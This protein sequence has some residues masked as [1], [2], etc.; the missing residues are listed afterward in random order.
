MYLV[1]EI[2]DQNRNPN[3]KDTNT[4]ENT[5]TNANK[6]RNTKVSALPAPPSHLELERGS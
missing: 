2:Y 6:M 1:L 3:F 4:I 5:N